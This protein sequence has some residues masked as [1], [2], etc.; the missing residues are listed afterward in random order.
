MDDYLC[1]RDGYRASGTV[2]ETIDN[3]G[4]VGCASKLV[5]G[6]DAAVYNTVTKR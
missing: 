1:V 5:N 6:S 3:I 4:N 2:D